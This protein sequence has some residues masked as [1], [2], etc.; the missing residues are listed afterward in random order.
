MFQWRKSLMWILL[1][2]L[3][4]GCNVKTTSPTIQTPL[5]YIRLPMGYIPNVQYAPFYVAIEKGYYREAGLE[6]EFD[7]SFETDGITLVGANE[8]QFT[9]ASGEQILLARAQGLPVV[10]VMGWWQA[11]PVGVVSKSEQGIR[12]PAD[13]KGKHIGLPGLFGA[14]YVGLRALLNS[15]A[16]DEKDV[17]LESIGFN[18]V[19]ALTSDQV[20]AVV[21]YV[22]NEP[23]QLRNLGY[24]V[25]VVKVSDYIQ[26]ASN[27]LVTNESTIG[28]NPALVSAMVRATLRGLKTAIDD[29]AE[30]YEISKLYVEN[31]DKA[32]PVV[33]KEILALS[34]EFWKAETLGY[35]DPQAWENMQAVLLDMNLLAQPLD[36]S[37]AYS[38][39]FIK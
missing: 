25:N 31:L 7:Y 35:T 8:L 15:A 13:L 11:Y 37:K 10:Y 2:L 24:E 12:L 3:V 21:V 4:S 18:Q 30:A 5:V 23:V 22:N 9:L 27:G 32:N 34:I 38:N 17:T 33:Q 14:S 1:V 29:P 39:D 16:L 28:E 36:L 26:L 19:E 6:V 20:Q